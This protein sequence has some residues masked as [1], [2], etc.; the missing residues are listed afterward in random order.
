MSIEFNS[1]QYLSSDTYTLLQLC[2]KQMRQK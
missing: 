1:V 2:D